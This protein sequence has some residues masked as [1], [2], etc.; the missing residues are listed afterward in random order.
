MNMSE[1]FKESHS[2][3]DEIVTEEDIDAVSEVETELQDEDFM[4]YQDFLDD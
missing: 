4:E 1:D 3:E 2:N